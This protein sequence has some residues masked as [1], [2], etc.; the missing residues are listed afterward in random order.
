MGFRLFQLLAKSEL[1]LFSDSF[2]ISKAYI[3]HL[4][5][6]QVFILF[7]VGSKMPEPYELTFYKSKFCNFVICIFY[8]I[9]MF[10]QAFPTL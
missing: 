2:S 8:K 6:S 7:F 9:S 1:V 5:S 10:F 4:K 3:S